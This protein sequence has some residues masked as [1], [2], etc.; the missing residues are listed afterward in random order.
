[1]QQKQIFRSFTRGDIKTA[2]S[3]LRQNRSRSLVTIFGIVI[4]IVAVILIVG[5]GEGVKHQIQGQVNRLG[6]NLIMV[7]PADDNTGISGSIGTLS[8][9]SSVRGLDDRDLQAVARAP[10]VRQAVPLSVIDG[11]LKSDERGATF[12][13]PI[14]A[15]NA[16]FVDV[17]HQQVKYGSFLSNGEGAAE[18]AVIGSNVAVS[19]FDER[20]PLGRTFEFRGHE[21]I[22]SGVLEQ[23]DSN[24]LLGDADFNNAIFI[25]YDIAQE[26]TEDHVAIYQI[27]AQITDAAQ[28]DQTARSIDTNLRAVHG[29]SKN[30]EVLQQG[31]SVTASDAILNLLTKFI[32][33]AAA[34]A[35]LIGGVGVMNIML[36]SVTERMHEIGIRKAVGATNWQILSQFLLESTVLS[37]IGGILGFIA[38]GLGI[39]LLRLFTDLQPTMPWMSAGVAVLLAI[40]V[41]SLFGCFPA[42]KA[43]RKDPIEALRNE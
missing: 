41:G 42:I 35:L 20:V 16:G 7:R 23:F 15:T 10:G 30:Y 24:P 9:P 5:I 19:L 26:L 22:V 8:G 11:T 29:G 36:V 31:Q 39:W 27:L 33:G 37:A 28:S 32:I 1:M 12:D 34:I 17:V 6:R 43:A 38:A 3:M 2:L 18:R 13:G 25:N 40:V 21:F 4:G 14:I